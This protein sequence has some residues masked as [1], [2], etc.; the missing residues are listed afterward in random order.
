VAVEPQ[1]GSGALAGAAAG[2]AG[3]AAIETPYA[4]KAALSDAPGIGAGPAEPNDPAAWGYAARSPT[5]GK[6]WR[7]TPALPSRYVCRKAPF[8]LAKYAN[9]SRGRWTFFTPSRQN[10]AWDIASL[11]D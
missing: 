10:L 5:A 3:R 6:I 9:S 7:T 4:A 1:P 2:P 8:Q 11:G